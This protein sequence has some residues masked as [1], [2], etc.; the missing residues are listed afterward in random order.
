MRMDEEREWLEE[1]F[2]LSVSRIA[3]V[4]E[5]KEVSEQYLPYFAGHAKWLM[6]ILS[7]REEA[8][9][10]EGFAAEDE[11]GQLLAVWQQEMAQAG[12][13]LMEERREELCALLEQF[14]A[15]YQIFCQQKSGE[16][17]PEECLAAVR[18][19][20]YYYFSDY[21]DV[22]LPYRLQERWDPSCSCARDILEKAHDAGF[23]DETVLNLYREPLS[24]REKELWKNCRALPESR[25]KELIREGISD[26]S[27]KEGKDVLRLV[28]PIGAERLAFGIVQEWEKKGGRVVLP[29]R[30]VSWI[31]RCGSEEF[32]Q[33]FGSVTEERFAGTDQL[34]LAL[35]FDAELRERKLGVLRVALEEF[36]NLGASLA[37]E[38]VIRADR[39]E[40]AG[41]TVIRTDRKEPAGKEIQNGFAASLPEKQNGYAAS[42]PEKQERLF[43]E[44][45]EKEKKLLSEY[46]KIESMAVKAL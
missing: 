40:P 37:G 13:L 20:L 14:L 19:S 10:P 3:A 16:M 31:C 38:I 34:A 2:A 35:F 23:A 7:S 22:K 11:M 15:V 26:F 27:V 5:E 6:E 33:G 28:Y 12:V 42:L 1:R 8:A 29:R 41:E 43:R 44:Y 46:E 39:E 32:R 24:F 4:R 18:E 36:K 17:G 45:A 25:I 21:A 30:A 9:F